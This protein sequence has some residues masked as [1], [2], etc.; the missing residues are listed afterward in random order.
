MEAQGGAVSR[1]R[2]VADGPLAPTAGP[3]GATRAAG[4]EP[5]ARR[6]PTPRATAGAGAP[7]TATAQ[8]RALRAREGRAGRASGSRGR[9]P[10][11]PTTSCGTDAGRRR[12]GG[13]RGRPSAP[14]QAPA[15]LARRPASA[16][17]APRLPPAAPRF[18]RPDPRPGRLPA[19]LTRALW[20]L[21][22]PPAALPQRR[23]GRARGGARRGDGLGP[24]GNKLCA[25]PPF[26]MTDRPLLQ[27]SSRPR[28]GLRRP[29]GGTREPTHRWREGGF[30]MG[31]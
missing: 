14:A 29:H 13:S 23:R 6:R 2:A 11:L 20:K 3:A 8:R 7:L 30:R 19:T 1:G 10:R 28:A 22:R 12:C 17:T 15:P 21:R 18:R 9:A 16:P 31:A 4:Q 5:A 24:P 25:Q 27:A 26:R